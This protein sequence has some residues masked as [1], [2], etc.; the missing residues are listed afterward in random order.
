MNA[1]M[2]DRPNACSNICYHQPPCYNCHFEVP[3]QTQEVSSESTGMEC[4]VFCSRTHNYYASGSPSKQTDE[5]HLS[6][7][8]GLFQ[9]K[10][11]LEYQVQPYCSYHS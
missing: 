9:D 7:V 11:D 5:N 1:D 3:C 6:S 4:V 2:E 10:E 8:R